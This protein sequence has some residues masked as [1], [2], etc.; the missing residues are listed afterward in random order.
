[1]EKK[2]LVVII[3]VGPDVEIEYVSDTIDS[4]RH[5][6]TPSHVIVVL[7][8]S[9]KGLGIA[10]KEC[11]SDVVVLTTTEV[12]GKK[13]GLYLTLSDGYALAYENYTFDVLLRLDTDSLV[14]GPNPEKDAIEYFHQNPD[15]GIIGSY[16]VD[17]NGDPRDYSWSRDQLAKELS[18]RNLLANPRSR[19]KG[20]FFLRKAFHQGLH[21]GYEAGEHCM[22]GAYFI[23][24]ECI[25]RLYKNNLLS[26]QE[27]SWS[28]LQEDHIIGLLI[29]LV[30]LRHGDFATGSL[31]MGLR[32]RGLPCSPEELIKR[33]KKVVHSTR[34]FE[35]MSEQTIRRYF[36]EQRQRDVT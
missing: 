6:V 15:C 33:K 20:W 13:V 21:N 23:S 31:P 19:L 8:D 1:M 18:L 9:G 26:R 32:W 4:I 30:G 11:F 29:Y 34:F 10:I 25:G 7:D 3:P 5:N 27:I 35:N 14:I 22:G 36:K 16:R 17:C 2:T 12:R 28:A 24:R